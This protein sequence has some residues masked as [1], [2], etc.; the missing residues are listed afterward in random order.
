ML[1]STVLMWT[2]FKASDKIFV[3]LPIFKFRTITFFPSPK[4]EQTANKL[5][6]WC[7]MTLKK[8]FK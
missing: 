7:L 4:K 2:V 5:G 3:F 8:H 1:K 6:A